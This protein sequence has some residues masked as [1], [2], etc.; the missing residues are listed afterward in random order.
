MPVTRSAVVVAT[1]DAWSRCTDPRHKR[2]PRIVTCPYE[3]RVSAHE[4]GDCFRRH[5][6]R[7]KETLTL[8]T[9]QSGER[10]ELVI[11]FYALADHGHAEG[12]RHRSHRRDDRAVAI[13]SANILNET[14]VD[15][16]DVNI[17]SLQVR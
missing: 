4:R 5:R 1:N 2:R 9:I 15:L 12:V 11:R 8:V 7:Q 3:L 13:A 10:V 16:H 6:T 17:H 14:S